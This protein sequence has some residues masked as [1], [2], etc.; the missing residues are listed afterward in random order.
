M[1]SLSWRCLDLAH[2]YF[3]WRQIPATRPLAPPDL[4]STSFTSQQEETLVARCEG[5][6]QVSLLPG[7]ETEEETMSW[8]TRSIHDEPRRELPM[9]RLVIGSEAHLEGCSCEHSSCLPFLTRVLVKEK[10]GK[11]PVANIFFLL[12]CWQQRCLPTRLVPFSS[13]EKSGTAWWKVHGTVSKGIIFLLLRDLFHEDLPDFFLRT[14]AS[15]EEISGYNH[16]T[17]TQRPK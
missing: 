10:E 11:T 14:S 16:K 4:A 2:N 12:V 15:K 3:L 17:K 6:G 5:S 9:L 7:C 1:N 8:L 13:W